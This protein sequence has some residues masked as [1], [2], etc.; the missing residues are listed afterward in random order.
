MKALLDAA[1]DCLAEEGYANTTT[2]RIAERSGVTLGRH[3]DH[4]A[5][6]A[7]CLATVTRRTSAARRASRS[8]RCGSADIPSIQSVR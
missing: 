2:R 1:V 8:W 5:S 7:N 3:A 6:K 4:F